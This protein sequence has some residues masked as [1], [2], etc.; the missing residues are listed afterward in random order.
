V[1]YVFAVSLILVMIGEL[2]DKSQL[3]ALVLATRYGVW[4]VLLGI[5]SATFVVHFFSAGFGSWSVVSSPRG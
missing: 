1:L 4:Q 5:L 3:L 2:A